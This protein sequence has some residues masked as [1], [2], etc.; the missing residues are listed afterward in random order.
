VTLCGSPYHLLTIAST[1]HLPPSVFHSISHLHSAPSWPTLFS[2]QP[3]AFRHL[4]LSFL[5][6]S[7]I[8]NASSLDQSCPV[9]SSFVVSPHPCLVTAHPPLPIMCPSL[10][11][12]LHA[13]S[14]GRSAD[15]GGSARGPP[16]PKS[17]ELTGSFPIPR[18]QLLRWL[19]VVRHR[20]H[21][22]WKVQKGT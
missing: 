1:F 22:K 10:R 7:V 12:G 4:S 15:P 16:C 3:L 11:T 18:K 6:R 17:A 5:H 2:F 8:S 20:L 21:H 19:V 13:L 9:T 14:L